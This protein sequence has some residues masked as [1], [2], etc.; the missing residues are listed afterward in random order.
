MIIKFVHYN[1]QWI[2]EEYNPDDLEQHEDIETATSSSSPAI[3]STPSD[4]GHD[5]Y[6]VVVHETPAE[7]IDT[8]NNNTCSS[9]LQNIEAIEAKQVIEL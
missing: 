4:A 5:S 1:Q 6:V 7:T 3:A 8:V 2:I 9:N